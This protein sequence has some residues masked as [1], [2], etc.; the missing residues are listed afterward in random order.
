MAEKGVVV[1]DAQA[2]ESVACRDAIELDDNS[3]PRIIQR[4]DISKGGKLPTTQS[5]MFIRNTDGGNISRLDSSTI[6][7][8]APYITVGDATNLFCFISTNND[9]VD[10]PM[11]VITPIVIA[12]S[13][14]DFLYTLQPFI[15]NKPTYDLPRAADNI[16]RFYPMQV[17]DAYGAQKIALH[18]SWYANSMEQMYIYGGVF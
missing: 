15:F 6:A 14:N 8:M 11:A 5:S 7:S 16:Q 13:T 4:I 9:E 18:V 3:N 1:A 12:P 2:G 17:Q 10:N